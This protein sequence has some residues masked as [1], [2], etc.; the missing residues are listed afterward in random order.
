MSLD[1]IPAGFQQAPVLQAFSTLVAENALLFNVLKKIANTDCRYGVRMKEDA[2]E[3]VNQIH[4]ARIE[5]ESKAR[6]EARFRAEGII[7]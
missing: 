6:V 3:V 2:A 5:A 7:E 1:L 4:E